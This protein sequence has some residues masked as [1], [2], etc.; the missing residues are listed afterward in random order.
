VDDE[1]LLYEPEERTSDIPLSPAMN[2]LLL[3]C[4]LVICGIGFGVIL[5]AKNPIA[6]AAVIAV[7]TFIGMV[8][9]RWPSRGLVS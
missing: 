9:K 8:M 4:W 5:L 2:C 3:G 1:G 7:P 6:G